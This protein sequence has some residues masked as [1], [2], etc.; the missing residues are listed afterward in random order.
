[1][2]FITA[3]VVFGVPAV[4]KSQA[5]PLGNCDKTEHPPVHL[6]QYYAP[7]ANLDTTGVAFK[8]SLSALIDGHNAYSYTP[9][10]WHIL[11]EADEH[12]NDSSS[13]L[14]IYTQRAIPKSRR[15]FGNNDPDSWN[16]E[17]VWAKSH[18]FP[19]KAQDAYTDAHHLVT[20]DRSCN[21]DRSDK[22]FRPGGTPV[23]ECNSH[24]TGATWEPPDEAKG[25]IARMMFYMVTRYKVT[26]AL[27]KLLISN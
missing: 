16:R 15:D 26:K 18:G 19:A 27:T 6:D 21:T 24:E 11:Q 7:V 9:C 13:V 10:V 2:K 25:A 17:H 12:P 8:A 3:L 22:D 14:A 1:M 20:A 23:D 5:P 4:V